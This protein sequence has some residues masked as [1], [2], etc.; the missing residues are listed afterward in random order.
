M[1]R[2]IK[3]LGIGL[4]I[5]QLVSIIIQL[6]IARNYS[7]K[8]LGEYSLTMQIG[9]IFS[10]IFFLRREY[11][12]VEIKHKILALFYINQSVIT[13]LKRL[14]PSL[15]LAI[16]INL[17]FK[18]VT[19]DILL[20]SISFGILLSYNI[21]L[22]Q[23]LNMQNRFLKSGISEVINKV[24]YLLALLICANFSRF[25]FNYISLSFLIALVGRMIYSLYEQKHFPFK[26]R[27]KKNSE[28]FKQQLNGL[29]LKGKTLSK[30]NAIASI[31]GLLP[32]LYV[33]NIYSSEDLGY[34]TMS[35]T[36]LSLPITII[37]NSISQ[38]LYKYISDNVNLV[39]TKEINKI[40]LLLILSSLCFLVLYP[41]GSF[42]IIT[43]LGNKWENCINVL[44][45]LIPNY[46]IS[47]ISKPFERNCYIFGKPNWHIISAVIKLSFILIAIFISII[48]QL[49]FMYYLSIFSLLTGLHYLIDFTYNYKLIY[50][51]KK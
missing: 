11:F 27:I 16:I 25:N 33:M 5:A 7:P 43:I 22:Q 24:I 38:V 37:G 6:V 8:N 41:F 36:L 28:L 19:I 1:I 46:I 18:K 44:Y 34:F 13:G 39:N 20:F 26:K 9:T 10:I 51:N 50:V 3:N 31:S 48:L 14:L 17:F 23:I 42:L 40:L 4:L 35:E 45:I 12:I 21:S 49:S 15:I 29:T 32:M 2:N 47:Y 30:N